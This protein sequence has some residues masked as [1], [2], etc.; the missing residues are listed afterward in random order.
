MEKQKLLKLFEAIKRDDVK[1]F[2]FVMQSNSDL[3]VCFGRFP[4]LSLLYLYGSYKILD[5]YE[6]YLFAINKFEVVFEPYEIYLKFKKVAKKSLKFYL[7]NDSIVYP[8]EMLG[9]LDERFLLIKFYKVLFKNEEICNNLQKIYKLNHKIEII[10]NT[11]D[12]QIK[13]KLL[14][15]F[16]KFVAVAVSSVLMVVATLSVVMMVL[17]G[18][19]SGLGTSKSPI[20]VSTEQELQV[21]I[22]KGSRY[23]VLQNDITLSKEFVASNFSG[24]IDGNGKTIFAED[25]LSDG[26]VKNLTGTIKNLKVEIDEKNNSI[27]SNIGFFAQN[28]K[29]TIQNCEI[30][31][32]FE[33]VSISEEE[34]Y[35]AGFVANNSGLVENVKSNLETNLRNDRESN[36]FFAGVVGENSGDVKKAENL[37]ENFVTDT[38]DVSGIVSLNKGTIVDS[39]NKTNISQESSKEWHPNT[40]GVV[41]TNYG[42]VEN[43]KNEG[44]I[45]STSTTVALTTDGELHTYAGGIACDNSGTISKCVNTGKVVGKGSIAYVFAGGI[46]ALNS[47]SKDDEGKVFRS[48]LIKNSKAVSEI[49]AESESSSVFVGGVVSRNLPYVVENEWGQITAIP[50]I[51]TVE[52]CGF[53]GSVKTNAI[54]AYA[55]GVVGQNLY[56]CAVKQSYAANTFEDTCV[57][58]G[59]VIVYSGIVGYTS[60]NADISNNHYVKNEK[61]SC[62]VKMVYLNAFVDVSDEQTGTKSYE[63]LQ[64]I[65]S[66]VK[67]VV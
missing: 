49:E 54:Q 40:S 9:I 25:Y 39:I 38:V 19:G 8:V 45:V 37:A 10:A 66:E 6:K 2:S 34:I 24:V 26:F 32:S 3:N 17:V 60:Q 12:I 5:K 33:G 14:N 57:K 55:G 11:K 43:C 1:S 15:G 63:N 13:E 22:K 27:D 7:K 31:G 4:L 20:K 28:S 50:A 48:G 62:A 61:V 36:V 35:L 58:A 56:Y 16:Q 44:N 23:F 51:A 53:E 46:A 41:T 21:A 42:V 59:K 65:P 47:C 67:D 30:A 52:S 64:A 29:G 18:K